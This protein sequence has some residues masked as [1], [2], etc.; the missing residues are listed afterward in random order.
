MIKLSHCSGQRRHVVCTGTCGGTGCDTE[1]NHTFQKRNELSPQRGDGPLGT[2]GAP[3][4]EMAPQASASQVDTG[5]F[6][7]RAICTGPSDREHLALP[8][9]RG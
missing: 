4:E 7:C 8:G 9:R 3:D 2:L 6:L 5:V 1:I